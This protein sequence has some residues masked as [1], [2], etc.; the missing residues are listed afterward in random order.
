MTDW[1]ET[2]VAKDGGSVRIYT[3]IISKYAKKSIGMQIRQ[4]AC[5]HRMQDHMQSTYNKFKPAQ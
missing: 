5:V 4:V 1:I 3:L 2:L